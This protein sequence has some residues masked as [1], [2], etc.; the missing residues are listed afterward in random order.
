MNT[1]VTE[2]RTDELYSRFPHLRRIDEQWGTSE[3]RR[4]LFSLLTDTR[5]GTRQ[6]FPPQYA[7]TV[8]SLLMEHDRRFPQF[9][10]DVESHDTRWG[11]DMQRRGVRD[12]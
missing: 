6:G 12:S 1:R 11:D 5:G 9:E 10:N 4:L 3:C 7:G 8:M 2:T